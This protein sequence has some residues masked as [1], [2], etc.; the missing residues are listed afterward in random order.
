MFL[1]C[2]GASVLFLLSLSAVL[3][4]CGLQADA[5]LERKSL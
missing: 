2:D 5:I 4:V 1:L 3:C